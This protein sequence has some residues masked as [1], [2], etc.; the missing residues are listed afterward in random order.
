MVAFVAPLLERGR[1]M[2]AI[3]GDAHGDSPGTRTNPIAFAAKLNAT[4]QELGGLEAIVAHSFGAAASTIAISNGMDVAKMVYIADPAAYQ[5]VLANVGRRLLKLP[6]RAFHDYIKRIEFELQ[7]HLEDMNVA[8]I[9]RDFTIPAL[10]LHSIDDRE[11]PH[12]EGHKV[13][14]AWPGSQMVTFDDLGHTRILWDPISVNQC[15]AFI[16]HDLVPADNMP[17]SNQAN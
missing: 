6:P 7:A 10:V 1:R 11:V 2:I 13:A 8:K 5:Q 9:I 16:S 12:T 17:V 4:G 15:I 3:D 14:D